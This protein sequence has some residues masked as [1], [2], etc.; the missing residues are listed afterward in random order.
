[1][2]QRDETSIISVIFIPF[3]LY[4]HIIRSILTFGCFFVD[5]DI[6]EETFSLLAYWISE[7]G[8]G[9]C[10][11]VFG[12]VNGVVFILFSSFT[13]CGFLESD[14]PEREDTPGISL[15]HFSE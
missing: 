11:A 13:M 6:H 9:I 2:I 14:Y 10:V 12:C 8:S 4:P 7:G 15:L 5:S 3:K 1:M